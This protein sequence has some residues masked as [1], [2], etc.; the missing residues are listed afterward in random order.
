M[1]PTTDEQTE[2]QRSLETYPKPHS[3]SGK[4]DMNLGLSDSNYPPDHTLRQ[5]EGAKSTSR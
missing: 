5:V 1:T 4:D 2:A 3:Q